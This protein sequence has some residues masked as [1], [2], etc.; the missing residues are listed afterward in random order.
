MNTLAPGDNLEPLVLPAIT[1]EQLK[2][3]AEASG[4]PNEIHLS[5]DAAQAVGLPGV[6][7]HGMLTMAFF[8][9]F[10]T[11]RCPIDMSL[12]ELS[13]RFKSMTHPGDVV[14]VVAKV[15]LVEANRVVCS[16]EARNQKG[17]VTASGSVTYAKTQ[18]Q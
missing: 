14:T 17:N 4:D 5:D 15:K 9:Q 12:D 2:A 1:R 18:N 3:Y 6:I 13:C 10:A 8:G 11:L 7:A 16:L